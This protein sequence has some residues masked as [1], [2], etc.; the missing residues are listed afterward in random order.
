[1]R[2]SEVVDFLPMTVDTLNGFY[3]LPFFRSSEKK[4]DPLV[5]F[6]PRQTTIS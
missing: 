6:H 5:D 3:N 2:R 1:M 4:L